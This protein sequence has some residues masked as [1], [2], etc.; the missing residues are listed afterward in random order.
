MR[1]W[2]VALAL[3]HFLV[4]GLATPVL[5]AEKTSDIPEESVQ[6]RQRVEMMSFLLKDPKE[7]PLPKTTL[8]IGLYNQAVKYFQNQEFVLARKALEDALAYDGQ[9]ALAYEL[10]GDIDYRQQRLADAKAHYQIAYNLQPHERIKEK[11]SKTREEAAIERKLATQR[12]H[13]FIIKYHDEE[14]T[15]ERFELRE[16]LRTTYRDIS[17]TLGYYF[18]PDQR[19]VVLLYDEADFEKITNMPHWVAG[20]YDG[21]VRMPINRKGFSDEDLKRLSAHEVTHAFVAAI[22]AGKAPLWVNEGL[23]QYMENKVK[24]IS[25]AVFYS[26]AAG[27][28]LFPLDDLLQPTAVMN[29]ATSEQIAL[30]YQQSF[31]LVNYLIERYGMYRL[32]RLLYQYAE[33]KDSDEAIRKIFKISVERLEREWKDSFSKRR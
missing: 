17:Q 16:L 18:K 22:S 27:G 28:D 29:L 9:L 8:A 3:G 11:I 14:Q 32:K 25:L 5:L 31:H 10:L 24:P 13:H 6:R 26:H 23:A 33:G 19:I 21:K 12:V 15:M 20:L 7:A 1:Y 30:F 4:Q 2:L